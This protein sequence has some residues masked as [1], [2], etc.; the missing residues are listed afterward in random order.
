MMKNFSQW[1][2]KT[3]YLSSKKCTS[4]GVSI[5]TYMQNAF[6][7]FFSFLHLHSFEMALLHSP[8]ITYTSQYY[9]TNITL[10][11]KAAHPWNRS[12]III[13]LHHI[14]IY[15]FMHSIHTYTYIYILY[16][17]AFYTHLCIYY[18]MIL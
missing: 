4:R 9:T 12:K 3:F 13:F 14:H 11:F 10:R 7:H 8:P 15:A 2:G 18:T 5:K 6:F 16:I 1:R 17:Y